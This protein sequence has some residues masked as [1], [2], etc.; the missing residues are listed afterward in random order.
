M[1]VEREKDLKNVEIK[2]KENV[3]AQNADADQEEGDIH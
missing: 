1:E 3:N 2:G